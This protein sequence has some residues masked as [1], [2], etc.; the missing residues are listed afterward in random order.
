MPSQPSRIILRIFHLSSHGINSN[1]CCDTK[2]GKGELKCG[3]PYPGIHCLRRHLLLFP[4]RDEVGNSR[5]FTWSHPECRLDNW[6]YKLMTMWP[7][8]R[9]PRIRAGTS[10][11]QK[12]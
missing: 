3:L 4:T 1:L 9:C 10:W 11:L 5:E 7:H 2:S 12:L 8:S 6:R